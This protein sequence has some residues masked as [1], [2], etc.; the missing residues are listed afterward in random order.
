MSVIQTYRNHDLYQKTVIL[1]SVNRIINAQ[2]S[3]KST[4]TICNETML[5]I[6]TYYLF[7]VLLP[8][9][10]CCRS[11]RGCGCG[12]GSGCFRYRSSGSV[13]SEETSEVG[14]GSFG[15]WVRDSVIPSLKKD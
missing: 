8:R 12:Y 9:R 11:G 2:V 5:N 15:G 14:I 3:R 6:M 1:S 4:L 7:T 10:H 13:C